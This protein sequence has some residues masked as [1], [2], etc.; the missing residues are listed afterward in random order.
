MKADPVN[1][2]KMYHDVKFEGRYVIYYLK[3]SITKGGSL[4]LPNLACLIHQ[5]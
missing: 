5:I 3:N 1:A 2:V 4:Y